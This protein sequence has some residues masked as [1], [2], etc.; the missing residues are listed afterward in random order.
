MLFEANKTCFIYLSRIEANKRILHVK[1]IK[2]E[3]TIRRALISR[4]S[5]SI[6]ALNTDY[7][8]VRFVS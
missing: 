1:R 8:T 4:V 5:C 7:V 3:A 2:M 6:A